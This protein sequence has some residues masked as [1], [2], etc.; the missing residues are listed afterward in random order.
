MKPH[1]TSVDL[2]VGEVARRAGLTVRT[3]HHYDAIGLVRPSGRSASGYR[4]YNARDIE[5]LHAVQSLKQL[6]LGL[7]AIAAA[8]AGSGVGPHEL[9][10]RQIKEA[11]RAI[12]EAQT[13]REKLLLLRDTLAAGAG[14]TDDLLEGMQLLA[15]YQRH[16]PGHGIRRLLGRWRRARSRWEPLAVSLAGFQAIGAPV[17]TPEVQRLAQQWMNVAMAVFGGQIATVLQWVQMHRAAPSTAVHAG[18]DPVLLAYLEQ[19]I[20]ARM[21]ALRRHL[22]PEDLARLDGSL[23]LEWEQFAAEGQ[24]LLAAG[25]PPDSM[26]ARAFRAS[27]LELL[28]RTVRHDA[29]LAEKMRK[30][31]DAEPILAHGH[32]LHAELRAYLASITA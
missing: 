8:L 18:L 22:T 20:E 30:A 26:A 27:Y 1:S 7:D 6:G 4:L 16:L 9:V 23:G 31:Y 29:A 32:F 3:L 13:L 14:C 24:V 17:A 21:A 5:R 28:A 11:E 12:H 15:T 2:T 10:D 19:A 25:T